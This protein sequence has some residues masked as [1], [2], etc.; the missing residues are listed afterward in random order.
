[1]CSH[2]IDLSISEKVC[3]AQND[4]FNTKKKQKLNFAVKLTRVQLFQ[5]KIAIIAFCL[6]GEIIL[7]TKTNI[8]MTRIYVCEGRIGVPGYRE[9]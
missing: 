2:K 8:R 1:M 5:Q 3:S 4:V 9:D 7:L 6:P